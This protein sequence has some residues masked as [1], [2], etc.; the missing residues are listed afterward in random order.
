[1]TELGGP[2]EPESFMFFGEWLKVAYKIPTQYG[3]LVH[4][5]R[6]YAR[7]DPQKL[8]LLATPTGAY[9]WD[10]HPYVT[11]ATERNYDDVLPGDL[12]GSSEDEAEIQPSG[13]EGELE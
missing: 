2:N 10:P 4:T 6:D 1:M 5:A 13:D 11:H 7:L 9:A 12:E 8:P 3:R